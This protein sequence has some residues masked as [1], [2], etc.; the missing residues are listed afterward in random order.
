LRVFLLEE[1]EEG[2]ILQVFFGIHFKKREH[3]RSIIK[4]TRSDENLMVPW[5]EGEGVTRSIVF[6]LESDGVGVGG[7]SGRH[8][9]RVR[10]EEVRTTWPMGT[11]TALS[12]VL[13]L[14]LFITD[15][16]SVN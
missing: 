6:W 2:I 9:K 15:E 4:K 13:V 8:Q 12:S 3:W 14:K 16:V 1:R 7:F 11:S 5:V 10:I